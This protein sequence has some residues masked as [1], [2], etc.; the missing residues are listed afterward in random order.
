[1]GEFTKVKV[2]TIN[3]NEIKIVDDNEIA[4][5]SIDKAGN[6]TFKELKVETNNVE[7]LN[8]NHEGNINNTYLNFKQD[9][10]S[11]AT[12]S[13]DGNAWFESGIKIG[14]KEIIGEYGQVLRYRGKVKTTSEVNSPRTGD[15]VI[16]E[17]DP[18]LKQEFL[19]FYIPED[20]GYA[21]NDF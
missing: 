7:T 18:N 4:V 11:K 13:S 10:I 20:K 5:A 3:S 14:N 6:G 8:I 2:N 21:T 12:I 1:M 19:G 16:S 17:I 15:I 9:D